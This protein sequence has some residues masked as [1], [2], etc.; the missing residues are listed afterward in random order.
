MFSLVL[1]DVRVDFILVIR[2]IVKIFNI[3]KIFLI[4]DFVWSCDVVLVIISDR[5]KI[6]LIKYFC[7]LVKEIILLR[8]I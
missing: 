5:M 1:L 4:K 3:F 6:L 2:I 8:V 7:K